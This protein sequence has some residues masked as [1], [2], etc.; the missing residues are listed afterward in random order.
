MDTQALHSEIINDPAGLGYAA[1]VA[2]GSANHVADLLNAPRYDAYG[3]VLI[4]PVLIW[5][6]KYGIMPRLRAATQGD[7]KAIA[8]I[9]EVAMMLV[10][11]PNIPA[12]DVG[13]LDVQVMIDHLVTA[14]VIPVDAASELMDLATVKRSR[15]EVL[16]LGVVTADDVSRALEG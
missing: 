2:T 9:A 16:G 12:L 4:T 10:S 13:L 15:A 3:K 1:D 7:D 14:G 5:L 6:A 8:G 11:N